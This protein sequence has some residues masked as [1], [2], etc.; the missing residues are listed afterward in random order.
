MTGA[1]FDALGDRLK[2]QHIV[3]GQKL[4]NQ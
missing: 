1:I 2:P 4:V 3:A